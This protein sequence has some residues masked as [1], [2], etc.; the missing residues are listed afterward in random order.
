MNSTLTSVNL[1]ENRISDRGLADLALA[2]KTN[3]TLK[4]LCFAGLN[5]VSDEGAQTLI[6]VGP[7]SL[8]K[9]FLDR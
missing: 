1:S 6:Q 3:N 4:S 7:P 2:L 9:P 8:E 5:Q